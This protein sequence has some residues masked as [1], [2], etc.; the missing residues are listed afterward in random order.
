VI[1]IL[2]LHIVKGAFQM[3]KKLLLSTTTVVALFAASDMALAYNYGENKDKS[4][5]M[6]KNIIEIA[7]KKENFST[8]VTALQ[9]A[10]L[11]GTIQNAENITVFAPTN[12]AFA[13]LPEGTLETLLKPENKEQLQAI[14]TY[15]VV[16]SEIMS[17]DIAMGTSSVATLQG[18]TIEVTKSENGVTVNNANV[19]MADVDAVNGVVHAIDTVILPE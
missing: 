6:E 3:I 7:T 13:K 17:G 4:A 18:G 19:I 10:D 15:H 1:A 2:R 5:K 12:E 8:L 16:G 14:L 9:A 11:V